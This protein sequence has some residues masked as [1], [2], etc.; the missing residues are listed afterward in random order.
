MSGSTSTPNLVEPLTDEQL[1]A[2][3]T[4]AAATTAA[5]SALNTADLADLV[6]LHDAAGVIIGYARSSARANIESS[7]QELS[8]L[9]ETSRN[10]D[11]AASAPELLNNVFGQLTSLVTQVSAASSAPI[12]T[13]PAPRPGNIKVR[14][15]DDFAGCRPGSKTSVRNFITQCEINFTLQ[16]L[17]FPTEASKVMFA[18]SYLVEDAF[19][20]IQ[21][22]IGASADT[23]AEP[24]N[25]WFLTWSAFSSKLNQIFGDPDLK[26]SAA[27]KILVL[28]QGKDQGVPVYTAEFRRLSVN[29]NWNDE[30]L[31]VLY[32]Q[33][34]KDAIKDQLSREELPASLI[35]TIILSERIGNRQ[36]VRATERDAAKSSNTSNS[37]THPTS[38]SNNSRTRNDQGQYQQSAPS[39][40]ASRGIDADGDVQMGASRKTNQPSAASATKSFV[41][42]PLT[43]DEKDRRKANGLCLYC[44]RSGHIFNDCPL[45][46]PSRLASSAATFSLT[47]P[48]NIDLPTPNPNF[49]GRTE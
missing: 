7:Y 28:H 26:A 11:A 27:R 31:R 29:L 2:Q 49:G 1:A 24:T 43:Q 36:H 34:L 41:R 5:L 9:R 19:N 39:T 45:K 35:E 25:S 16:P 4:R 14:V 32:Y 17:S 48:N 18:A 38:G 30:T 44:G 15:P 3:A 13:T 40:P 8:R 47:T 21:P 10:F 22:Y 12:H 46:P 33:G 23:L 42:G 6:P 20:W 37:H